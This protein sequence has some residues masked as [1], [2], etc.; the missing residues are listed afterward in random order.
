M[1]KPSNFVKTAEAAESLGVITR[2]PG[3]LGHGWENPRAA[4]PAS[5]YRLFKRS[6]LKRFLANVDQPARQR[7]SLASTVQQTAQAR[8]MPHEN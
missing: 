7:S 8:A 6:D 3:G 5:G 4:K 1:T 2:H